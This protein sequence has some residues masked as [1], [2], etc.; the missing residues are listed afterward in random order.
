MR[1]P[2]IR[3]EGCAATISLALLLGAACGGGDRQTSRLAETTRATTSGTTVTTGT[4]GTT[5]TPWEAATSDSAAVVAILEAFKAIAPPGGAVFDTARAP[6][7]GVAPIV[8]ALSDSGLT[9]HDVNEEPDSTVHLTTAEV[10]ARLSGRRGRVFETLVHLG[11]IYS[12]PHPQYSRL[13][14]APL[15]DGLAVSVGTSELYR[16]E[17]RRER[18]RLVL[19]RISYEEFEAE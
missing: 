2:A 16:L 13:S 6:R 14:F 1:R 12:R 11:Y 5:A 3:L 8:A 15:S 19:R 18:G 9:I 7:A 10:R 4:T 17:F